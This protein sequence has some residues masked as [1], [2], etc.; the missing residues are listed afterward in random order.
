MIEK[1][2]SSRILFL[3][4]ALRVV[5][6]GAQQIVFDNF[7]DEI[8]KESLKKIQDESPGSP[9]AKADRIIRQL[10]KT[11]KFQSAEYTYD[12]EKDIVRIVAKPKIVIESV[13][14][15][16]TDELNF[17]EVP[18]PEKIKKGNPFDQ[19][20]AVAYAEKIKKFYVDA[21]YLNAHV[22]INIVSKKGAAKVTFTVR[23]GQRC[24]IKSFRFETE[25]QYLT[26]G[27]A[28]ELRPFLR[29]PL[30]SSSLGQAKETIRQF[31]KDNGYIRAKVDEFQIFVDK[32]NTAAELTVKIANPY[33][34]DFFVRGQQDHILT[35]R[36]IIRELKNS[37][38]NTES[39][40][41]K[42]FAHEFVRNMY[43]DRG[44][45]NVE[46]SSEEKVI[47]AGFRK[48]VYIGVREGRKVRISAFR[49]QGL[50]S[51]PE[52]YY[53]TFIREHSSNLVSSG[54]FH[55]KEIE[56]GQNNLLSEL[57]NQGYL[58]ARILS[59]KNL[60]SPDG[61]AAEIH[62]NLN[63]G[64]LTQIRG[65]EFAGNKNF[66]DSQLLQNLSIENQSALKLKKLEESLAALKKFYIERGFLEMK[67]TNQNERLVEYNP[68]HTEA[69]IKFEIDEGPRI[70]VAAVLIQGNQKTKSRVI[71]RE[72]EF[73]I[74]D[75]LTPQAIEHSKTRLEKLGLFSF[76][77]ISTL[78]KESSVAART[79]VV[80]VSE[81][82]PGV[83]KLGM[84]VTNE[85]E[86]TVRGYVAG[87]YD[88]IAGTARAV[89][90]RAELNL[91]V[92]DIQFPENQIT[93][94]YLEPYIFGRSLKGRVNL[95]RSQQLFSVDDQKDEVTLIEQNDLNLLLEK[96]FTDHFSLIYGVYKL[97]LQR[98]FERDDK[99]EELRD[100]VAK[101]GPVFEWDY[102]DDKF[103]PR[104]GSFSRLTFDYA[105]PSLGSSSTI[106][107][108]KSTA[109][110][111]HYFPLLNKKIVFVNSLRS[112][113]AKNLSEKDG[114]GI[115]VLEAFFLGGQSTVRGFDAFEDSSG[116]SERFP[117]ERELNP[118][119]DPEFDVETDFV[120]PKE[121]Y[122]GL[123]K[124]EIRFPIHGS[125]QGA[126]FYDGGFVAVQGFEFDDIYRDSV[127]F[128]LH[129]ITPVGP[130]NFEMGF[131]L[132]R[133]KQF[134]ESKSRFHFSIGSF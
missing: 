129:F 119:N 4:L 53:V 117:N 18:V 34:Y 55:Q 116:F 35:E 87:G 8:E 81:K 134:N 86:L 43:L 56:A 17:E 62:I 76:I 33:R 114:S 36:T 6:C 120:I 69:K 3:C 25:N 75:V 77:D 99:F 108:L 50:Y 57:R 104:Q 103:N 84:G 98:T 29:Q 5:P 128:G 14:F 9:F 54:Y 100:S 121:S 49:I 16:G 101:T 52:S 20:T 102:R 37:S 59:T 70:Q 133:K 115:P 45:A 106:K 68:T 61:S 26:N 46:I 39:R 1:T 93:L 24:E 112:G 71:H 21:G 74:G 30:R 125:L 7:D 127:G 28:G 44:F 67:V 109:R 51:R 130:V 2:L 79:V 126:L 88:N 123:F 73:K 31:L 48:E 42:E 85:R 95:V 65:I 41:P 118:D 22:E 105:D 19:A 122:F 83:V 38:I 12:Q 64:P 23:Q 40:P 78:E 110:F 92:T 27:L 15:E 132:D 10:M 58:K 63:E 113:Y 124:S 66:S 82:K 96:E 72:L 90:A 97:S 47:E 91:N 60:F 13:R 131:K 107:F 89:S 80:N 11:G 111:S 32:E 94:G